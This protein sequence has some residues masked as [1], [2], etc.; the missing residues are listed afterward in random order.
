MPSRDGTRD[1]DPKIPRAL[2]AAALLLAVSAVVAGPAPLEVARALTCDPARV[3]RA[4]SQQPE[5]PPVAPEAGDAEAHDVA[6]VRAGCV[7]LRVL[8]VAAGRAGL[9]VVR[10]A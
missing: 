7:V 2:A 8:V 5:L 3:E 4:P 10:S 9:V 1:L 6:L